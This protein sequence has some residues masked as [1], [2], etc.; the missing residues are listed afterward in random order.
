MGR[1]IVLAEK[2]R[3]FRALGERPE[4]WGALGGVIL[5]Q[6]VL[7]GGVRPFALS[8]LAAS[9]LK[10]RRMGV[11]AAAGIL[12]ALAAGGVNGLG[13]CEMMLV[14]LLTLVFWPD[15]WRQTSWLAAPL[16]AAGADLVVKSLF[17]LALTLEV[18]LL[19]I[20]AESALL[21][22]MVLVMQN[23]LTSV[24]ELWSWQSL[25]LEEKIS[26]FV[27]MLALLLGLGSWQIAGLDIQ[28]VCSRVVVL[29]A[30]SMAGCGGGAAVGV[31]VGLVPAL[32]GSIS[33]AAIGFYGLAGVLGG[34]FRTVGR[35]G[36]W[37]GFLAGNLLLMLWFANSPQL[38]L[39]IIETV[40]AGLIFAAL[41]LKTEEVVSVM[42]Q[43]SCKVLRQEGER[44]KIARISRI[45]IGLSEELKGEETT[46]RD[47][48]VLN[49]LEGMYRRVYLQVCHSCARREQCWERDSQQLYQ[50]F[51]QA[52]DVLEQQGIGQGSAF[53][54]VFENN[55]PR[56]AQLEVALLNQI[57]LIKQR[58]HYRE[59]VTLAKE[60]V[61]K[62][63]AGIGQ[64][65]EELAKESDYGRLA[66]KKILT[67]AG[68]DHLQLE[69]VRVYENET[70]DWEIALQLKY[71]AEDEAV[72]EL[73]Q[74][75]LS[76]WL[77]REYK[78]AELISR[79]REQG[80]WQARLLPEAGPEVTVGA[81]VETKSGSSASGDS[82]QMMRLAP[83]KTAVVLS[84]G[85][86]SGEE[87][88]RQS[89]TTVKLLEQLLLGGADHQ[90]ALEIVN[91]V[92]LLRSDEESFATVDL[93]LLDTLGQQMEF[94]K[95]S[96]AP[97][98]VKRRGQVRAFRSTTLPVGILNEVDADQ[99]TYPLEKGDL[100]VMMSDGAF[101]AYEEG[102][103]VWPQIIAELPTEEP[104]M[105]ADYLLAL[106][107]GCYGREPSDD[108]T[109]IVVKV[110][111]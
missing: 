86:G 11:A 73:L 63:L 1:P 2:N 111:E 83:G 10:E 16:V 36:V 74:N 71:F 80:I 85:M 69:K 33:T 19:D 84:D 104:Q 48:Q 64:V 77:K 31:A 12:A 91:A 38:I 43:P 47:E 100:L 89:Q 93:T 6:A 92:L 76:K 49:A 88:K 105:A 27:L 55:C 15:K 98:F 99:Q 103:T 18:S 52:C 110:A 56:T 46:S 94:I 8:Y 22:I 50:A 59:Q 42:Q 62:Q 24:R 30:A 34:L 108:L 41:P 54:R 28:S 14:C 79:D 25:T 17:W 13:V 3:L 87:A 68:K 5:G 66:E 96:A 101:E 21:G 60:T 107:V 61:A 81:A 37:V 44:D 32:A 40:L 67:L 26:W 9:M 90:L 53:S 4:F 78:M 70:E 23:V 75:R 39:T 51:S 82:W 102:L 58:E 7:F 57:D 97:S 20:A 106:A 95:I 35:W 72:T 65:V 109:V 29:A 45:F